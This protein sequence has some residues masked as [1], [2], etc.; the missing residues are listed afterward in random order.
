MSQSFPPGRFIW[1]NDG[2]NGGP[3][4]RPA[5]KHGGHACCKNYDFCNLNLKPNIRYYDTLNGLQ[6]IDSTKG[7]LLI[8]KATALKIFL[9]VLFFFFVSHNAPSCY[10]S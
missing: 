7:G 2:R 1:C 5:A 6:L 9:F 8:G 3:T 10:F 4:A